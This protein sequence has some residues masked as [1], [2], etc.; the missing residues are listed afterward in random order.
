[1]LFVY[2]PYQFKKIGEM[3]LYSALLILSLISFVFACNGPAVKND[4]SPEQLK[5]E[6]ST[7]GSTENTKSTHNEKVDVFQFKQLMQDPTR[8]I[9]DL[10]TPEETAEGMINGAIQIDYRAAGF[11]DQIMA[12]DKNKEYLIYCRSGIRSGKTATIMEEAGFNKVYDLD[13]GYTA[14]SEK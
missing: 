5:T 12:L 6:I 13:G 8:I 2:L 9:I 10:R 7:N 14:W 11:Q 1:M 3:K 4:K